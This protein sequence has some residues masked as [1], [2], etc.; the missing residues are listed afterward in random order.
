MGTRRAVL[1]A[2][3]DY[4]NPVNNLPSC[5]ADAEAFQNL[6]TGAPYNFEIVKFLTD[7]QATLANTR[8]ALDLL[9]SD[10]ENDDRLIFFYSG[11]G[12]QVPTGSNLEEV[13]VLRDDFFFDDELVQRMQ[14]LPAGV[15][16][17]ISDSCYSGGLRK[18]WVDFRGNVQFARS[19]VFRQTDPAKLAEEIA[20]TNR[21][22]KP[23]LKKFGAPATSSAAALAKAFAPT[24]AQTVSQKSAGSD[25][26]DEVNQAE[27][28]GLLISACLADETASA[29]TP[30]TDGMSAFTFALLDCLKKKDGAGARSSDLLVEAEARLR[31]LG[32]KQTPLVLEPSDPDD[33]GKRTFLLLESA[34]GEGQ[35]EVTLADRLARELRDAILNALK[36]GEKAVADQQMGVGGQEKFLETLLPVVLP[37]VVNG[38]FGLFK[39]YQPGM[40]AGSGQGQFYIPEPPWLSTPS[41]PPSWTLSAMQ[42]PH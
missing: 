6:I 15:L 11:H 37:A 31:E 8:E 23:A 32:F 3:N 21:I 22:K 10:V 26:S 7:D 12:Y 27:L 25:Q 14:G 2:I 29:S 40:Q 42:R 36:E 19:K 33:L 41:T 39:E 1:V 5:V 24:L 9:C 16:T 35:S 18:P 38:V 13:L 34:G 30:T 20:K 28:N 17:V 4:G